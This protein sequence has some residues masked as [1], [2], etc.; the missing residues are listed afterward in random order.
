MNK[1]RLNKGQ[2][3]VKGMVETTGANNNACDRPKYKGKKIQT[4]DTV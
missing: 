2:P 3:L 1:W 4:T